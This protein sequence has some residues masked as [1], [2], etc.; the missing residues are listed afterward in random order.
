M[1]GQWAPEWT[2][3]TGCTARREGTT[4]MTRA[5]GQDNSDLNGCLLA[6]FGG[7]TVPD[8]LRTWLDGGLAGVMLYAGNITGPDQLRSL[9]ARLREH[10]PGLL[11]AVDEE[12]GIVTRLEA[13]S[14]SSYP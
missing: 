12:G 10:N 4:A 6:R 5:R 9:V 14:G 11:I 3:C 13:A 8:W 7:T 1:P 2:G